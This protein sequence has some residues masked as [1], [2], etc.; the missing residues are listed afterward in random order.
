MTKEMVFEAI[1]NIMPI[2]V[3]YVG[4]LA[5]VLSFVVEGIKDLPG[6]RKL[7]T[8]LVVYVT[9]WILTPLAYMALCAWMKRPIDWY[10]V[11]ANIIAAFA[12]AKV[13]MNGWD[14]AVEIVKRCMPDKYIE[15]MGGRE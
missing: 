1:L 13:A 7:P 8:K 12:I 11:F 9:A 6:L 2:L 4:I 15:K 10:M 14:D 5:V 3:L